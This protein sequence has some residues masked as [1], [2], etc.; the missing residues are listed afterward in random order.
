VHTGNSRGS[1][2]P[3]EEF[4]AKELTEEEFIEEKYMGFIRC[5]PRSA[6]PVAKQIMKGSGNIKINSKWFTASSTV[7]SIASGRPAMRSGHP[8]A[9]AGAPTTSGPGYQPR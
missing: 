8:P 1:S 4:A 2:I 6:Y 9:I 5:L 3:R 7:I